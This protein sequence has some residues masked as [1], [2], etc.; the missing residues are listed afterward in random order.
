MCGYEKEFLDA[1]RRRS[2]EAVCLGGGYYLRL[3]GGLLAKAAFICKG[4]YAGGLRLTVINRDTGPVDSAAIHFWELP[5][6]TEK[7][8]QVREEDILLCVHR[9]TPDMDALAEKTLEYLE[10][11]QDANGSKILNRCAAP[12]RGRR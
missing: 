12:D 10:L 4:G 3:G 2:L 8:D 7:Q 1:L 9:P 11:F 5:K 6:N